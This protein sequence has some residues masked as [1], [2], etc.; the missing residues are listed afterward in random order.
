M[1]VM[2]MLRI[3][4]LLAWPVSWYLIWKE[5]FVWHH[6]TKTLRFQAP[7][8]P[9]GV[10]VTPRPGVPVIC[11]RAVA[12][13]APVVCVLAFAAEARRTAQAGGFGRVRPR[14]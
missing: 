14:S 8:P 10:T 1:A 9:P 6:M 3:V 2:R 4:A 12:V 7:D 5:I 11:L 13:A